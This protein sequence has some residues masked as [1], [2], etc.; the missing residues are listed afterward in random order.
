MTRLIFRAGALALL[1][2]CLVSVGWSQ[3]K[4]D[5]DKD[6]E[7]AP[8]APKVAKEELNAYNKFVAATKSNDTQMKISLGEEFVAKYP[9]SIYT[10][11]VQGQLAIAY[12]S[13]NQV[14]KLVEAG[15]KSLAADPNN[16]DVLPMM[17][18]ALARKNGST[19]Q[20]LEQSQNYAKRALNLLSNMPKPKDMDDKTFN[21]VKNQK[22]AQSHSAIGT[23]LFKTGKFDEA[24]AEL[25]QAVNTDPEPDPVDYYILGLSNDRANHFTDAV[26]A[27]DKCGTL[28]GALAPQCKTLSA[29]TKKKSANSLEAPK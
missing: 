9:N 8:P 22:I 27:F 12:M 26:A 23:D 28:P 20:Q 15:E 4:K 13:L 14:D 21:M 3:G 6:S 5:K 19:A 7:Q 24:V 29:E 11:V 1:G 16:I 2:L 10:G 18:F 25:T 17:A